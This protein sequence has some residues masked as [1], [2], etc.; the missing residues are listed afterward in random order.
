MGI[1]PMRRRA[2]PAQRITARSAASNYEEN[3]PITLNGIRV[4]LYKIFYLSIN[5]FI[6][7]GG[8]SK[9]L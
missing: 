9:Y 7:K 2:L 5:L 8:N 3:N 4:I 1:S 6:S